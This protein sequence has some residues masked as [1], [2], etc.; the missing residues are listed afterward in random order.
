MHVLIY[1]HWNR[2]DIIHL[3]LFTMQ[4]LSNGCDIV[5]SGRYLNQVLP[6]K[7]LGHWCFDNIVSERINFR[8]VPILSSK[9]LNWNSNLC[10]FNWIIPV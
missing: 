8:T 2:T 1:A 10:S 5:Y 9:Q 3:L 7:T 6:S 4:L